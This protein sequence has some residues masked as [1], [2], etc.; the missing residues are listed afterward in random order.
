MIYIPNLLT[1][2]RIGM[3]PWLVVLLQERQFLLSLVVFAVAGLTDA[4]DG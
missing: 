2:A 3:V 1:L 4:L